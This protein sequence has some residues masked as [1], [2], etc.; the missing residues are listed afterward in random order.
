MNRKS[1]SISEFEK[2]KKEDPHIGNFCV[3]TGRTYYVFNA[4]DIEGISPLE[5]QKFSDIEKINSWKI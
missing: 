3:P 4:K 1:Y 5:I 2:L